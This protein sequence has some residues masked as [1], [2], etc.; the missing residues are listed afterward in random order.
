VEEAIA[1]AAPAAAP[2]PAVRGSETILLVE[3][4]EVVRKLA[5]EVLESRGYKVLDARGGEEALQICARFEGTI[6]L[7]LT[8]VV[9]PRMSGRTLADKIVESRPDV[10]V[11]FMSGTRTM[12]SP[13][14]SPRG[15][16]RLPAEAVHD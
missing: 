12:R 1:E 13:P 3:D 6:H 7:M 8:D 14:R 4:E 11:L 2:R 10:R 5:R 9:M 15:G 16:A